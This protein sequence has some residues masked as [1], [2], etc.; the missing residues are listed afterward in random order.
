MKIYKKTAIILLT[1]LTINNTQAN[2]NI[3]KKIYSNAKRVNNNVIK[4]V[5][6][7]TNKGRDIYFF[8]ARHFNIIDKGKYK[9]P[10]IEGHKNILFTASH[11]FNILNFKTSFS[12]SYF[13]TN[14]LDKEN[15]VNKDIK[16]I[17]TSLYIIPI[18]IS[19]IINLGAGILNNS[20]IYHDNDIRKI[21]NNYT[22][23]G[24]I[25]INFKFETINL[26]TVNIIGINYYN[27][28]NNVVKNK[29]ISDNIA[30]STINPIFGFITPSLAIKFTTPNIYIKEDFVTNIGYGIKV[31][32]NNLSLSFNGGY[33]FTYK[34]QDYNINMQIMI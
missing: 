13:E 1:L 5:A 8:N 11:N 31:G 12:V 3:K 33:N 15:A 16:T 19:N 24:A 17:T 26:L 29:S 9:L 22:L 18:S 7:L 32:F 30:L 2:N 28:D 20:I 4:T 25:T 14:L 6:P 21:E 10:N 34:T 23:T 27:N